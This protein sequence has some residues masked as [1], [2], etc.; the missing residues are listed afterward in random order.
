[1]KLKFK[2][3]PWEGVEF[4]ADY[5]PDA[6]Q[7]RHLVASA[8][9]NPDTKKVIMAAYPTEHH[10]YLKADPR[11]EEQDWEEYFHAPGAKTWW[12]E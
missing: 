4:D 2:G 11:S 12:E 6:I 10:Q 8:E 5:V 3:G 7:F 9:Y 1:M